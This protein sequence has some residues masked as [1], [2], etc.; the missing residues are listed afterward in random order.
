MTTVTIDIRNLE[1]INQLL[2]TNSIY[3]DHY[4]SH[5]IDQIDLIQIET[6]YNA[7]LYLQLKTEYEI[8]THQKYNQISS[9]PTVIPGFHGTS[10]SL[11][12][13]IVENGLHIHYSKKRMFFSRHL[14]VPFCGCLQ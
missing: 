14:H 1:D 8:K 10:I 4:A 11:I 9:F 6:I 3:T 13:S 7:K 12:P 2:K 5:F